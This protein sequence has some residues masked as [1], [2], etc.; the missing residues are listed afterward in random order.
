MR[1]ATTPGPPVAR[2]GVGH[3]RW[4]DPSTVD[5]LQE[6]LAGLRA[7]MRTRAVIEQAKG[8]VMS[9][10]RCGPEQAFQL[11]VRISQHRHAKLHEVAA[12]MVDRFATLEQAVDRHR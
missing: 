8:I 4:P 5:A 12:A 7:A 3:R 9:Q 11:L 6:E 1:K 10:H 2:Q